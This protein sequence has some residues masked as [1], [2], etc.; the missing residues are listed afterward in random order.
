MIY[1]ISEG[2]H[3]SFPP[4]FW[5]FKAGSRTITA[6]VVI[7]HNFLLWE[8]NFDTSK[9]FGMSFKLKPWIHVD[10]KKRM[11][12]HHYASARF[13]IKPSAQHRGYIEVTM[14]NYKQGNRTIESICHIEPGERYKFTLD[15]N[16]N[17]SG[18]QVVLTVDPS[19]KDMWGKNGSILNTVGDNLQFG[20]ASDLIET[21][22]GNLFFYPLNPYYGG[23]EPARSEITID[24]KRKYHGKDSR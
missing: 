24:L 11:P 20:M 1:S 7:G 21:V 6:E 18:M 23:D 22:D 13:G 14:Y 3:R 16:E 10:T 9:L 15:I 17:N 19:P 5:L 4:H 8:D 12:G 2:K